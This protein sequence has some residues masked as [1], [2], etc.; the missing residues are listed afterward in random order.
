MNENTFWAIVALGFFG[1]IGSLYYFESNQ[2]IRKAEFAQMRYHDSM[3]VV[4]ARLDST[5]R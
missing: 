3:M 2:N 1:M 5:R 4:K